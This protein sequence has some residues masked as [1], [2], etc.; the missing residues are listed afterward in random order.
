M[1][2]NRLSTGSEG[3]R[4]DPEKTTV[5]RKFET[6]HRDVVAAWTQPL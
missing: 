1:S 3:V 6:F 5:V 2:V 4:N